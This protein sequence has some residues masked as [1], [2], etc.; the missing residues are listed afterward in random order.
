[1]GEPL[2]SEHKALDLNSCSAAKQ[3]NSSQEN[4]R[5]NK[6]KNNQQLKASIYFKCFLHNL[7]AQVHQP[8]GWATMYLIPKF[9][10]CVWCLLRQSPGC[11]SLNRLA[12][13]T[14]NPL[15]QLKREERSH[16]ENGRE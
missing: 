8:R 11:G 5:Q 1:V 16:M 9:A 2:P 7:T 14:P 12:L 13:A 10:L 6:D 3:T 15:F 4:L